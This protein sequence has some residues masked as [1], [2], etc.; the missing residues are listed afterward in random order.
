MARPDI[1]IIVNQEEGYFQ[2]KR[3]SLKVRRR[4][5]SAKTEY[6]PELFHSIAVNELRKRNSLN[7]KGRNDE[8]TND[9]IA[10]LAAM[11]AQGYFKLKP[12]RQAAYKEIVDKRNKSCST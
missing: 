12:E 3:M 8:E 7:K 1:E 10:V 9:T 4:L 11:I 2:L 6:L 5:D